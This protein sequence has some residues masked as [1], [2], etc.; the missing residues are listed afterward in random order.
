[1][2]RVLSDPWIIAVVGGALA[3]LIPSLIVYLIK[4]QQTPSIF[5][6]YKKGLRE[7]STK[8]AISAEDTRIL[9]KALS[10]RSMQEILKNEAFGPDEE[11][12]HFSDIILHLAPISSSLAN[13]TQVATIAEQLFYAEFV[14][15]SEYTAY[16]ESKRYERR[17]EF[18][19]RRKQ[20]PSSLPPF[21]T[22]Q[23]VD[24]PSF[25]TVQARPT[26]QALPRP[27]FSLLEHI[28]GV[29]DNCV[30][31]KE[32]LNRLHNYINNL[33]QHLIVIQGFGG[34]G[35]T[36][37]AAR[38]AMDISQQ[39][40]VLWISC[41]GIEVTTERFLHEVGRLAA[42]IYNYSW[43]TDIVEN[44]SLSKEEKLNGLLEFFAFTNKMSTNSSSNILLQPIALFFDDYHL[45]Q[46][47]FFDLFIEKIVES[48][49]N[50]KVML[51]IRHRQPLSN[52]LQIKIETANP[53]LL[54]GL[55]LADC[56]SLIASYA[57]SFP[58]LTELNEETLQLIW[59]RTGRGVPNALEILISMT[60][61]RS[62]HDILEQLPNYDPLAVTTKKQWFDGLFNELSLDEQQVATEISIFR[63][64]TLRRAIVAVSQ[65]NRADEI[66]DALVNRFVLMFDGKLYSMHVLWS[67]Y[68]KQRLSSTDLKQLH[69]RAATFYRDFASMR[70]HHTSLMNQIMT[71]LE[72]CHH[73]ILAEDIDSTIATLIPIAGILRSWG[74]YNETLTILLEIEERSKKM[75]KPLAPQLLLEHSVVLHEQG[76]VEKA[77]AILKGLV[78]T[79]TG[80]IKSNGLNRLAWMYIEL[81]ERREAESCLNESMQLAH[82]LQLSMLEADALKG[83]HHLAYI[84]SNYA[85]ALEYNEQRLNILQ[86]LSNEP[87]AQEPIAMTYRDIGNIY[88]EQG[89]Y[90]KAMELYQKSLD[91]FHTI[92]YP[93]VHTGWL[94]YD[95]GRI[96]FE[97]DNLKEAQK[98][99]EEALHLFKNI[100][101]THGTA[102]VLIELALVGIKLD[103]S[104]KAIE[105][106]EEALVLLRHLK[107]VS[108]EAYGL[109]VLGEIYLFLDNPEQALIYLQQSLQ[110]DENVLHGT[111]GIASTLHCM[112]LVY[113]LQGKQLLADGKLLEASIKFNEAQKSISRV[114]LLLAELNTTSNFGTVIDDATRIAEEY[115]LYGVL[116]DPLTGNS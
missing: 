91:I 60:R 49:L 71:Q 86:Q 110:L 2:E 66:I 84:E 109:R 96:L 112:S 83:L 61:T 12:Q 11:I 34:L 81:G 5:T 20:P 63:R 25:S 36:T 113:E 48:H 67:D 94:K 16:H 29:A 9:G 46:D 47:R 87:N 38:F 108:G 89:Y 73:F 55:S 69:M 22:Q 6:L 8:L 14:A 114:K 70:S 78:E 93:P 64:P 19:E 104:Y 79:N 3:T 111:K 42:E 52:K 100:H 74:V 43:L 44:V 33:H 59:K 101:Y 13:A 106:I 7:I 68:T 21:N 98:L 72:S 56:H 45:I 54:D 77:V 92:G 102:H 95:I 90:E 51:I 35:K 28:Q 88:R 107:L 27:F 32:D 75:D 105:Q 116:N 17:R 1:M 39:Y 37:L 31:R 15:E 53:I 85:K 41:R 30:G 80:E 26:T 50:I 10:D 18:F 65:C 23:E 82:Q 76:E 40:S 103:S 62:L 4:K 99:F 57:S 24:I 115:A 58:M 97:L